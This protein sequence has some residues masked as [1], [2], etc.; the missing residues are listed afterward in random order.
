MHKQADLPS[1]QRSSATSDTYQT[2]DLLVYTDGSCYADGKLHAGGWGAVF[3]WN[4]ME[5]HLSGSALG[6]T[7]SVMEVTAILRA[8]GE[9]PVGSSCRKIILSDSEYAVTCLTSGVPMYRRNGWV[10]AS[11]ADIE[12]RELL[13]ATYAKLEEVGAAVRW[14]R[15]HA[16]IY[17]NEAADKL[18]RAARL[19]ITTISLIKETVDDMATATK[20]VGVNQWVVIAERHAQGL[21]EIARDSRGWAS[22]S[23]IMLWTYYLG[24]SYL[25]YTRDATLIPDPE[26]DN[27]C[28]YLGTIGKEGMKEHGAYWIDELWDDSAI[29]AGTGYQLGAKVP[30]GVMNIADVMWQK[31]GQRTFHFATNPDAYLP[32]ENRSRKNK[33]P[34]APVPAAP[35]VPAVRQRTRKPI[36][37]RQ[38]ID[39][40]VRLRVRVRKAATQPTIE[41]KTHEAVSG[42]PAPRTRTRTR[43]H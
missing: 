38:A 43:A 10:G 34:L 28:R 7:I 23:P 2:E 4:G 33:R 8:A 3:L 12:H 15:G 25:Y 39:Q 42:Q 37:V 5:R 41:E 11:G 13:E 22:K 27:L 32:S 6:T 19:D 14:C 31:M 26:F 40:E 35:A 24:L 30:L 18:A 29:S 9:L 36:P 16:G 21:M 20:E 1:W 17:G